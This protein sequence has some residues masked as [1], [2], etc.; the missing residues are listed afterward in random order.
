M[1][2]NGSVRRSAPPPYT[3]TIQTTRREERTVLVLGRNV[4]PVGE[5]RVEESL[6]K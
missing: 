1:S 5:V 3:H 2:A 4:R 6:P